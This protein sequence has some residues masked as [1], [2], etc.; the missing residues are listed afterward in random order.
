MKGLYLLFT[1]KKHEIHCETWPIVRASLFYMLRAQYVSGSQMVRCTLE[2]TSPSSQILTYPSREL[3]SETLY[4]QDKTRG[5]SFE[6]LYI[7]FSILSC[8]HSIFNDPHFF[9]DNLHQFCFIQPFVPYFPT[10]GCLTFLAIKGFKGSHP[11]CC[12]ITVVIRKFY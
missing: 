9:S 5:V 12:L 1:A 2:L 10:Q 7:F 6:Y 8:L 4:P 11:N 3:P